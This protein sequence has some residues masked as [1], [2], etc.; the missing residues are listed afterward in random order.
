MDKLHR[1]ERIGA[2]IKI[3]ADNPNRIFTL[4]Y[5]TDIFN[6]AKSTISEDIVIVKKMMGNFSFGVVQTIPGAAGGVKY[7]PVMSMDK[8]KNFVQNIC[9]RLGDP[10]RIIPGGFLYMTDIIYSPEIVSII[11]EILATQF[12][13]LGVDYVL[14]VET[15]GIPIALMTARTLNVPLVIV[16]R[17]SKVTEGSTVSINYVSGS[18]KRIQTMSLSRR[19]IRKGTK[20]IFIDDFMKAGGTASGIIELMKEFEN[21]VV[22]VGVL[23]ETKEPVHKVVKKYIS[24]LTLDEVDEEKDVIQI[25]P[26]GL[27]TK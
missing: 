1:N 7:I 26:S 23:I 11:G 5:F 8:A 3:L 2:L 17:D 18:T 20:S 19:A 15:K 27:F 21:E 6:A 10:E 16:R 14:T 25:E 12:F 4:N 13:N 9:T 22:G 24:L